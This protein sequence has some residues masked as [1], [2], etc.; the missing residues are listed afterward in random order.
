MIFNAI[1]QEDMQGREMLYNVVKD[2][3]HT[4]TYLTTSKHICYIHFL[5]AFTKLRK[6]TI[7]FA[8]SVRPSVRMEQLGYH[9]T[10]FHEIWYLRIFR[11]SVEKIQV[12]LNSVK[13]NVHF[14]W[15]LIYV[16]DHISLNSSRMRNVSDKMYRE[17]Q[18]THF[19]FNNFFFFWKSYRLCDNV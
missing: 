16:F 14:T 3:T 2:F 17:N 13:N 9:W 11:K 5:C 15:I 12:S 18:N 4:A 6:V 19:V 7:S 8:M 1:P 10:D